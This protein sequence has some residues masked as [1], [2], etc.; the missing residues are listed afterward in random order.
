MHLSMKTLFASL[1]GATVLASP[2]PSNALVERN[3]PLNEFLSILLSHLPA[4]NG[5]I[6][7]VSGLITDFDQVLADLTGAQTTQNQ[8]IG[9]CTE[10]TVLFARGTSEPGNVSLLVL[11]SGSVFNLA[12]VGVLVGPPLY[13]AF[14]EAVGS[15]ALTFQGVNGYSAS[16]ESYLAGGDA[17]GSKSM[18][19][20]ATEILTKCP[21]TKLIMSG[22]SQGCQVVHN[23]VEQLPA[24]IASKISSVLLFGD[25]YEG[26]PFPNVDASRVK[27]VCHAGDTICNNSIIILP[28][29]L[30][31]AV[32]VAEAAAF[33]I[34]TANR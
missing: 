26:K 16:V 5:S 19:S 31:Y 25:P 3:A 32:N 9:V 33:A 34:A 12:Q 30:T 10:Y 18:A 13:E 14:E 23:A 29:H 20:D 27:T 15:R 24:E 21:D 4:I 2:L 28:A 1:L 8:Y 22:Y 17:A 7:A 11:R 6:T